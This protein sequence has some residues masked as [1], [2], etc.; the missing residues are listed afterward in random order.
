M[1]KKLEKAQNLIEDLNSEK[2]RWG[3][4][5]DTL[6]NNRS[7]L[8]GESLLCSSFLSYFGPFDEHFR[9]VMTEEFKKDIASKNISL[10]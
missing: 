8:I 2:I 6:A 5:K 7:F 9:I 1:R 4:E 10:N 3:K